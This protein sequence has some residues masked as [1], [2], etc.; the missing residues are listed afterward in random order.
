MNSTQCLQSLRSCWLVG[1]FLL[2]AL[3][4]F[5]QASRDPWLILASGD[6]VSIN[7]HTTHQDLVRTYGAKNVVDQDVDL[8]E[9]E[10]EPGTVLFPKDP[11][12]EIEI[13]WKHQNKSTTPSS[14]TIRGGS[15][16]WKTVH[17]ISLGTSLKDL[18]KLNGRPF[19]LTGFGWDYSG[20]LTSWDNGA[21]AAELDGGHGRVFLRLSGPSDAHITAKEESEVAGEHEFSSQ[22]SVMQKLNPVAYE[23]TWVF[24]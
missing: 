1:C 16:R 4:S 8:G 15:S 24:P 19:H 6:K 7:A 3:S 2:G 12:C 14:L 23:L 11:Q 10:T 9:G 17:N 22:N 18:E 5:G 20:T 13:L 21:L